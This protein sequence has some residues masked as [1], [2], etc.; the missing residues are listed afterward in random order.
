MKKFPAILILFLAA[1]SL[2]AAQESS[3]KRPFEIGLYG[4][5]SFGANTWTSS[6]GVSWS[7]YNV[8]KVEETFVIEA[9]HKLGLTG[10]VFATYYFSPVL[11]LQLGAGVMHETNPNTSYYQFAW[12]W[13]SDVDNLKAREFTGTGSLT[14]MPLSLNLACRLGEESIKGVLSA[15]V[16]MFQNSIRADSTF[17]YG[18]D[19]IETVFVDPNYVVTQYVDALPVKIEIPDTKWTMIG[20]NLGAGLDIETSPT[21]SLRVDVRYYFCP[22]KSINW[23]FVQG[24]YDGMFYNKIVDRPFG[25][26]ELDDLAA[27]GRTLTMK[28][29]PSFFQFSVGFFLHFGGA[30]AN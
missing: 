25:Q 24:T 16:S 17:G 2:A 1:A 20:A 22:G 8:T 14:S 13:K 27:R 5:L 7:N 9:L 26:A 12:L 19:L 29:N 15:G 3:P 21:T 18:V 10:G 11:G 30:K 4:G 6:Y 23:N 28:I